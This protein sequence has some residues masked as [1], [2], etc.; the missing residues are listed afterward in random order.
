MYR[1][2]LVYFTRLCAVAAFS[3]VGC[4]ALQAKDLPVYAP[5]VVT[6]AAEAP[7]GYV[8]F[9]SDLPEECR[10]VQGRGRRVVLNQK[11]WAD[12]ERINLEV[13]AEI[14]PATD[15]DLFGVLE[16]WTL[17]D[18]AGD[19]EDYVLLKRKRLIAAGWPAEA[20]LVTVVRDDK[21]EGHAVLTVVTDKGDYALDN[22][23]DDIRPW[24]TTQYSFVKR[25]SQYDV[26][27]WVY[28]GAPDTVVGVAST[29]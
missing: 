19:C 7:I 16:Y 28:V 25:Q 14:S 24:Q 18:I 22:Q 9:C 13:N 6:G 1:K 20:L 10:D 4:S 23:R 11:T 8:Q 21:G 12:L 15:L 26:N 27:R 17:P 5:L 3:A 29:R 2:S